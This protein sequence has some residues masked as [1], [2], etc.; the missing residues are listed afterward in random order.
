MAGVNP[1]TA[2]AMLDDVLG[3]EGG[4]WVIHNSA[5]SAV[6]QWVAQVARR[7]GVHTVNIVRRD[8]AVAIVERAGGDVVLVD[9]PDLRRRINEATGGAPIAAGLEA[10][11]GAAAHRLI[12]CVADG[13]EVL[14]Y[15]GPSGEPVHAAPNHLIFRDLTVRGFW[16]YRWFTRA[17]PARVVD[18]YREVF[19]VLAAG[20]AVPVGHVFGLADQA[21]AVAAST[22]SNAG[23]TLF[24]M[25]E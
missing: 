16:L 2:I 1:L 6:G 23:K 17:D 10:V 15:A 12:S 21:R 5:N 9:G 13:G 3:L 14:V 18:V 8:D 20:F 24:A 7:R 11:G 25:S 4:Q 22:Q 19:D